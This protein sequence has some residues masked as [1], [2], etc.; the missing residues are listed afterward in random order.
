MEMKKSEP[1]ITQAA[2]L[3]MAGRYLQAVINGLREESVNLQEKASDTNNKAN[4]D[5]LRK[6]AEL[7]ITNHVI[8]LKAVEALYQI[9]TGEQLGLLAEIGM[10][11]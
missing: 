10:E 2:I 3:S 5:D 8:Y 11:V 4:L 7:K 1:I 6:E 9:E